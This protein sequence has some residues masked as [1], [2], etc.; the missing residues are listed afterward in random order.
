MRSRYSLAAGKFTRTERIA[1]SDF[2]GRIVMNKPG[3]ER[4]DRHIVGDI[5][6]LEPDERRHRF[7]RMH[8]SKLRGILAHFAK[9]LAA[10]FRVEGNRD[11]AGLQIQHHFRRRHSA[12]GANGHGGAQR[13][14]PGERQFFQSGE[15]ADMH[16]ALALYR[17]FAR[18]DKGSLR[19]ISLARQRLHFGIAQAARVRKTASGLPLS[20]CAEKTSHWT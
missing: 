6:R 4:L 1:A 14:M 10:V 2:S 3:G 8:I 18:E 17:G 5:F 19:E 9:N 12:P 15:D 13:G 7:A 20:G 11:L 16:A